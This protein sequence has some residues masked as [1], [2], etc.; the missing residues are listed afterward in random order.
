[1]ANRNQTP[2]ELQITT[3]IAGPM[4]PKQN[5]PPL[6]PQFPP[7]AA[8]NVYDRFQTFVVP[9]TDSVDENL[10]TSIQ[11]FSDSKRIS[12]SL[13]Y[14]AQKA[15][16]GDNENVDEQKAFRLLYLAVQ[17]NSYPTAIG[18]LGYCYEFGIGCEQDFRK[19]EPLY[20]L[21]ASQSEPLAMARLSFLKRYGRPHVKINKNEAL[22]LQR[23]LS[24][25][26]S[27]LGLKGPLKWLY[28]ASTKFNH[29]AS[30]YSLG[31]CFHDGV[32]IEKNPELAVY[33]YKRSAEQGHP[34]G[35]GI[36]GYCYGEGFGVE[37]DPIQAL[38]WYLRAAAQGETV[39]MYNVG[40]CYE[41]GIGLKRD[42][43]QA[44]EWYKRAAERGN[45]LAANSL[46]YFHE[47]GL[48]VAK[49]L[50]QAVY[51][52][53]VA[54]EL[55]NPWAEHN[56]GYMFSMGMGVLK[57]LCLSVRWFTRA[58]QQGHAGAQN[59][60][61]QA[62]QMGYGVDV[63]YQKAFEWYHLAALQNHGPACVNLAWC[64]ENGIGTVPNFVL[65]LEWIDR[66]IETKYQVT[67]GAPLSD[68]AISLS[69]RVD[70]ESAKKQILENLREISPC[71]TA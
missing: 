34:R 11:S 14:H 63:D 70:M 3:Y 5:S 58:A 69:L 68:W 47:E 4:S 30:Q 29:A 37:K 1:M 40:Y 35:E 33:W 42:Y 21:A 55:G 28:Y 61:G 54:A 20:S 16:L 57:D 67:Q 6:S 2:W 31:T 48:G 46:G 25:M 60:L 38:N 71:T 65:A 39:A 24:K 49:N 62:Y 66:A 45:G 17:T 13:V 27:D 10:E 15:M 23:R 56:L 51:W 64:F 18:L 59:R 32:G 9:T 26:T 43:I 44:L 8:E 7:L 52:Y 12:E 22:S 53:T 41:E 19:C 50:E 36:L